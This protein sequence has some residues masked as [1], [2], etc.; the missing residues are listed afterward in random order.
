MKQIL[1]RVLSFDGGGIRGLYQTK[2]LECLKARGLDLASKADILAGTSTG[3]IIAGAL[4]A[5]LEP[6]SISALYVELGPQVFPARG[7]VRRCWDVV[8]TAPSYSSA[9]LRKALETRLGDRVL[10]DCRKRLVVPA[11]SLNQ[12]KLK[13][14]DSSRA[15]DRE[16]KLVDVILA[17]AAA[18]TY[19]L[20]ARVG[21]TY[22]VDGGLCC[23]NP[24]FRAVAK[25]CREGVEL[26][27]IYVLSISTGGVPVTRAGEE[28]LGLRQFNWARPSID[29]AM[30]GSSDLAVQDGALVGYHYRVS[31]HLGSEIALDDYQ[32]ALGVLPALAE[33]KADD[34]AVQE[35]IRRWLDGPERTGDDLTGKWRTSFAWG[36]QGE[37]A[38]DRLQVNQC[39]DFVRGESVPG[40]GQW[41]YTLSGNVHGNALIGEWRGSSLHG[42]F[43]LIKS[44]EHGTVDGHWVGTGDF[45][46]YF[47]RWSWERDNE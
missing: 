38:H 14:F 13:V 9:V 7:R 30:S 43:L 47:G 15:G 22:Y 19:F 44:R 24:A 29:L 8:G 40:S 23:N 45:H 35:H 36:E 20:P 17:S 42:S 18:P 25:L 10:R 46:P 37:T 4:A 32:S 11:I 6:E 41:T 27:K 34:T 21:A 3:S 28:F 1:Y 5:G 33:A 26:P 39:G 12:Y 31:E 2:L 16:M